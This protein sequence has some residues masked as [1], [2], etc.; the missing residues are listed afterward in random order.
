MPTSLHDENGERINAAAD[1][2]IDRMDEWRIGML[3]S[4]QR[5]CQSVRDNA[6]SIRNLNRPGGNTNG[7]TDVG[8]L[9]LVD[10][11]GGILYDD[12]F[13]TVTGKLRCKQAHYRVNVIRGAAFARHQ[14]REQAQVQPAQVELREARG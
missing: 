12:Y 9:T 4:Y 10:R 13:A 6:Q 2:L 11:I 5:L 8:I 3:P 1:W 7:S 14:T